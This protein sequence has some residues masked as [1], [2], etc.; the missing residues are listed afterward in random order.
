MP[1]NLIR[2]VEVMFPIE[3]EALRDR[4]ADE[5]LGTMLADNVKARVLLPDGSYERVQAADAGREPLRS[6]QRFIELAQK[7]AHAGNASPRR[8][9]ARAAPPPAR[10]PAPVLLSVLSGEG[11]GQEDP[12]PQPRARLS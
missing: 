4:L 11:D 2:R 6:Q 10:G 7:A 3:D 8:Y 12:Q 1:R 5:V 9:R